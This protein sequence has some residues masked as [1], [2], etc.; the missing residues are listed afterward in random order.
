MEQV[1]IAPAKKDVTQDQLIKF[2]TLAPSW[3][4]RKPENPKTKFGHAINR[5]LP[6][7]NK[8]IKPLNELQV[9]RDQKIEEAKLKHCYVDPQTKVIEYDILK[10][11]QGNE[12]QV[13]KYTS[14]KRIALNKTTNDILQEYDNEKYEALLKEVVT[15]PNPYYSVEVPEDLTVEEREIFAGIVIAPTRE[16]QPYTLEQVRKAISH[17]DEQTFNGVMDK[18]LNATSPAQ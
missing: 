8:L 7:I 9:E 10:D 15:I 2:L 5:M 3:M 4:R 12:N 18:L 6:V 13:Y 14:D 1:S 11:G 16:E 17:L